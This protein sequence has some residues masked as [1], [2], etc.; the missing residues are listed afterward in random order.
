[1]LGLASTPVP[2][3]KSQKP[4]R[5]PS[6]RPPKPRAS[7]R[8]RAGEAAKEGSGKPPAWLPLVGV[9]AG[10]VGL[11]AF[12]AFVF[13]D[14][15]R[16]TP[17]EEVVETQT[18][19]TVVPERLVARVHARYPHREDAFTQGLVW[20]RGRLFESTG[21]EGRSSLREVTLATGVPLRTQPGPEDVFAEGLAL[22]GT[23][24]YQITW[25]DHVAYVYDRDTFEKRAEHRYE[26]EGWGL[27]HD[28][29]HLVMSD[30]S[31]VLR[32]RDPETFSVVRTLNVTRLGRPL[33]M[34][35][36]LECVGG[37][38][39]AN[40]WQT[41]DIVRIDAET[42]AVEAIIDASALAREVA[43]SPVDVLNGIA[44]VPE[45]GRF[46]VTGKLW[47]TL[48]EVTFERATR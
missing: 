36:E 32:F 13:S 33:R 26:G 20:E 12:G 43:R 47:P 38:V 30:G 45:R 23:S 15:A 29:T 41:E 39:Y 44:Y 25:Q 5:T 8:A 27:C 22:V 19:T 16:E 18:L 31:D 10:A 7:S 9:I 1:M 14:R 2:K 28:G 34:L 42:G 21:L 37:D 6:E 3:P 24:L 17:R 46:L 35:N 48:F 40:V 4:K 11:V